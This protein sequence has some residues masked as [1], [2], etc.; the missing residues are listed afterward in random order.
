MHLVLTGLVPAIQLGILTQL[1]HLSEAIDSR[2]LLDES[3]RKVS[4]AWQGRI[5]GMNEKWPDFVFH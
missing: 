1:Y 2:G 4:G 5:S 3:G